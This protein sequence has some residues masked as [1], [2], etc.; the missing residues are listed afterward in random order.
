[1]DD[2]AT[3]ETVQT[4]LDQESKQTEDIVLTDVSEKSQT[5]TIEG[6][7]LGLQIN[8]CSKNGIVGKY[9][10]ED[11]HKTDFRGEDQTYIQTMK[12][13][14]SGNMESKGQVLEV[15]STIG[16]NENKSNLLR[17]TKH[18]KNPIEMA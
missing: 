7:K 8:N 16:K 14:T 12:T 4:E 11:I 15:P 3:L 10:E 6:N 2:N 5:N 13:S 9:N 1:M 17:N 18:R